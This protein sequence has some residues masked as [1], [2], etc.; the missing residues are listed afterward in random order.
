VLAAAGVLAVGASMAAGDAL[1]HVAMAGVAVGLTL[2]PAIATLFLTRRLAA[3]HPLGGILAMMVGVIVRLVVAVGGAAA[4]FFAAAA[5]RAAGIG[6]WLWVLFA[7]LSTLIAE[8]AVLARS[9][10]PVGVKA[11]TAKG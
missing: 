2:P 1:M 11:G 6:F 9:G 5:F 8:T 4:I 3:R 10:L 7:Y